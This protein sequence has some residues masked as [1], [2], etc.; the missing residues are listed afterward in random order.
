M[1]KKIA[2]LTIVLSL[3]T[4]VWADKE[5]Q[6]DEIAGILSTLT[7]SPQK[8]WLAAG[9]IEAQH[10]RYRAPDTTDPNV[11]AQKIEEAVQAYQDETENVGVAGN[12]RQMTIEAI[13]FN[14]RYAM[15]NEYT[16]NTTILVRYDGDRFYW[17]INVDSREDSVLPSADLSGN[18]CIENFNMEGN[19]KRVFAWDGQKYTLY[20]RPVKQ[21]TITSSRG[22]VTGPLTAGVIPWGYGRYSLE[23][24]S[25]AEITGTE[26]LADGKKEVRLVIVDADRRTTITLDADKDYAV[27]LLGVERTD[28]TMTLSSYRDYQ[29]VA[30][31]WIPGSITIEKWD[32]SSETAK[33]LERDVWN[34]TSVSG[35]TPAETAFDVAFEP[36]TFVED[37]CFGDEPLQYIYRSSELELSSAVDIQQLINKRLE[38]MSLPASLPQNCAT[39][40]LEYAC[41]KLGVKPTWK[42]LGSIVSKKDNSTSL[43]DMKRFA[44]SLQG[45]ESRAIKADLNTLKN[46]SNC[47]FILHLPIRKHY[48]VLADITDK[49]VGLID[50]DSSNFYYRVSFENFAK[51]WQGT[52]LLLTNKTPQP[53]FA[54]L[55]TPIKDI[56]GADGQQCTATCSTARTVPCLPPDPWG[57]VGYYYTY[58][59]R[60]CCECAPSGT[61]SESSKLKYK[62]APCIESANE[63]CVNNGEW[64]SYYMSACG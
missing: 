62:K 2:V 38:I 37:F 48:V 35:D 6:K 58:Y 42:Q 46:S 39:V 19:Q 56:V 15:S 18:Y 31:K 44:D 13:P 5:L 17:E 10:Q 59:S 4:V 57:C 14:V 23:S 33:L 16:M 40:S 24:L 52:A 50:L 26:S 8:T 32:N 1:I 41:S 22:N 3:G 28:S 60:I 47:R 63:T 64:T 20:F 9:T 51:Q 29:L 34:F 25:A 7:Q 45:I 27:K 12:L 30:G 61:C 53:E 43:L 11:I 36:D 21:A 49:G 54:K 55:D